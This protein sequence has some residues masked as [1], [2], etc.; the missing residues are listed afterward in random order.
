MKLHTV[1]G[2]DAMLWAKI[3]G[4]TPAMLTFMGRLVL[5]PPYILRPTWR[6]AYCTG[7]RR[8]AS[9]MNTMNAIRAS[10]PIT[11]STTP[12][13]AMAEFSTCSARSV[14]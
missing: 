2:R 11:S 8:S 4:R 1:M 3:T 7:M 14:L 6:L 12:Q 9:L 5:W 10:M 13:G